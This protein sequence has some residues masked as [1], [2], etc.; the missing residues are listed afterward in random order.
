MIEQYADFV[1]SRCK[2]GGAIVK[3]MSPIDAHNLHMVV[4]IAGESGELLDAIKKAVI[5]RKPIDLENIKEEIGDILFYIQGMCNSI[6]YS[7]QEAIS[8][9]MIKLSKRYHTGGYSDNQAQD[10]ADKEQ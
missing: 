5:Y 4:G 9:N 7:I 2:F 10:R 8:D 6:D 3:D 1:T